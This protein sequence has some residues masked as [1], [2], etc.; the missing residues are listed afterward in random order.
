MVIEKTIICVHSDI[1]GYMEKIQLCVCGLLLSLSQ[2]QGVDT[3][4]RPDDI[5]MLLPPG[6]SFRA[7][8]T[9]SILSSA[10]LLQLAFY[11]PPSTSSSAS[12]EPPA[13]VLG[14]LRGTAESKLGGP[15]R[16]AGAGGIRVVLLDLLDVQLAAQA[17]M[18]K[19]FSDLEVLKMGYLASGVQLIYFFLLI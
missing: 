17:W 8:D 18:P 1:N 6:R 9:H 3:E 12:P 7:K 14:R 4:W 11:S 2:Q 5:I 19:I 15:G 10:A 16:E 13:R